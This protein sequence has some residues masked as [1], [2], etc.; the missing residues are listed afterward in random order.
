MTSPAFT[1]DGKDPWLN[2]LATAM[3]YNADTGKPELRVS[4]GTETIEITGPVVIPGSV[5]I[6]NDTGNPIPISANT[7]TNTALNPIHV[8]VTNGNI[9]VNQGTSPWVVSGTVNIGTLPEVEIKNDVGNPIPTTTNYNLTTVGFNPVQTDAFGRFR[10]SEPYTLFDSFHRFQDN[11]KASVYTA[12]GGTSTYDSAAGT[13]LMNVTTTANSEV[14]RESGRVFAYQPGK[15]LLVLQT[16]C[17]GAAVPN[18]RIRHGYFDLENGFYIQRLGS[19]VSLVKRSSSSGSIVE[20]AVNQNLWNV[21]P[22]DGNGPSGISLD[23]SKSQIMWHD[24]EWLGVGT[25]RVGFVVNGIFYPV[26]Y[27]NHANIVNTTYM[28]TACLPV[29]AEIKA[30]AGLSTSATHTV[31][32]TSVISEGG[33]QLQGKTFSAGHVL[34]SPITL[35]NTP[36]VMTPIFSLRLKSNRLGAIALPKNFSIAPEAQS[37]FKYTIYI[38][39]ITSGGVWATTGADSSVEYNLSPTAI[40]SGVAADTGFII[41]SNQSLAAPNLSATPFTYQLERNTLSSPVTQYEFVIAIASTG[42]NQKIYAAVGWEE[43]T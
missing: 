31:I 16:Y 36:T 5:E 33:Y 7:N 22:M 38:N 43:V 40:V 27:W 19:Q 11:A 1:W 21:D 15:S 4:L 42:T 23:F 14:I 32:C 37:N 10:V 30:T 28:T 24:L 29:R 18:L 39:A 8:N 26:H 2:N 3:Q 41:S 20:T 9:T 35:P 25:V 17:M 12:N 13:V 34:G 6:N